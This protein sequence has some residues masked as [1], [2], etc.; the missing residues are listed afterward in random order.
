MTAGALHHPNR[1]RCISIRTRL[2]GMFLLLIFVLGG[3]ILAATFYYT[4]RG[5][6]RMSRT[7]AGRHVGETAERLRAFFS[8][9]EKALAVARTYAVQGSL[10]PRRAESLPVF[11]API[12]KA[13][14]Q[15]S[16]VLLAD[17]D[18]KESM[19]L[20]TGEGWLLRR[21]DPEGS[22]GKAWIR[23]W[24]EGEEVPA[25]L[26]E[27]LDYD[28]R[29]RPWFRGVRTRRG[30]GG[31]GGDSIFWTKPYLFFTTKQAGMTASLPLRFPSGKSGVIAFDVLL[32]DL[33]DYT[34]RLTVGKRGAVLLMDGGF[35][36]LGLPCDQRFK[37]PEAR[38]DALLKT[39]AD[40][41]IPILTD[42]LRA[43]RRV[44]SGFE[45][46]VFFETGG[47]EWYSEIRP[48]PLSKE[49]VLRIAVALPL[50]DV[51]EGLRDLWWSVLWV[52]LAVLI[53]AAWEARLLA[54][55]F[56]RPIEALVAESDRISR[57]LLE[58]PPEIDACMTELVQ[59]SEAQE[60]LRASIGS[61]LRLEGDLRLARLIQSATLPRKLP[62]I[63]GYEITAW[64]REAEETGGDTY[65]VIGLSALAEGGFRIE[66]S[67]DFDRVMLVMA[68]ATGHGIGPALSVTQLRS[69]LRMAVRLG[70]HP[71]DVLLHLNAQ[72]H[73]DL[74]GGRFITAW[75][76][77]LD[78]EKGRFVS[79]SAGQAPILRFTRE[80]E[81]E[82][83]PADT[84]PL[85]IVPEL[86]L[87]EGRRFD[88]EP[89]DLVVALSDGVLEARSPE[90]GDFGVD[91]AIAVVQAARSKP[92]AEIRAALIATLEDFTGGNP[93]RDDRTI[94]MVRRLP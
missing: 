90:G 19:L 62:E 7:L 48:F 56:T 41:E 10:D 82:R 16:S 20:E 80:E 91:R 18:G 89:G 93:P 54:R 69:M 35:R 47:E 64:T 92:L 25:P 66:E 46:A 29:R 88:L 17:E 52:T 42:A 34:T 38:R 65:D 74:P 55:R 44:E 5:V 37:G 53:F 77:M 22:P 2:L 84:M 6:D 21:T 73:Q 31:P 32:D 39:P 87:P 94:L 86:E 14:P 3:S 68:D 1:M 60:R 26:A 28:A 57:G 9:V 43:H 70:A 75:V 11:L 72:L 51:S 27:D 81:P 36:I 12:L 8:P 63:P 24:K 78:P 67:R 83:I 76:G 15:V 79:F 61:L 45:A 30:S 40:L 71:R 23:R 58:E 49:R 59:L 33:C 4:G 85:G 13:L 50:A